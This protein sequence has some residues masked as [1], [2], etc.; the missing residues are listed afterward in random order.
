MTDSD[1]ETAKVT[2]GMNMANKCKFRIILDGE[3][4]NIE[5]MR[6]V[7]DIINDRDPE[8]AVVRTW[9]DCA[10]ITDVYVSKYYIGFC[11]VTIEGECPWTADYYWRPHETLAGRNVTVGVTRDE[12]GRL[13]VSIPYLCDLWNLRANGY[14]EE[15]GCGI[16]GGYYY[17][18]YGVDYFDHWG[19]QCITHMQTDPDDCWRDCLE[20][21]I[22]DG[23]CEAYLEEARALIAAYDAEDD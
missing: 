19:E 9:Q 5:N 11:Y 14:E 16:D 4:E 10:T 21:A 22:T 7:C 8:Y 2:R 12:A 17:K 1:W 20:K 18:G 15:W 13:F 3:T 23:R 6:R